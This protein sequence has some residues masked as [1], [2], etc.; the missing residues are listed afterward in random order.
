MSATRRGSLAVLTCHGPEQHALL[1][2]L[3]EA[4]D[5]Q[6]IVFEGRRKTMLRVLFKRL[7]KL[8][9]LTLLDQA[10]YKA[11]DLLFLKKAAT[12]LAEQT[13]GEDAHFDE[14]KFHGTSIWET[15]SINSPTCERLLSALKPDVVVVSGVSLLKERMLSILDGIPVINIHCGV[16]PRYRGAHGA[17]WAIVNKDWNNIGATVHFVDRGIDTGAVIGQASITVSSNDTPR[18]LAVKQNIAGIE[19][20]MKAVSDILSGSLRTFTRPDLD[21]RLYSSPTLTSYIA[22]RRRLAEYKDSR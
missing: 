5:I 21:S 22:F 18:S 8:G 3:G 7:S 15:D 2:R 4:H 12:A 9:L 16:T 1:N 6:A 13:L 20:V 14:R 11:L 19:L 17:F 10:A